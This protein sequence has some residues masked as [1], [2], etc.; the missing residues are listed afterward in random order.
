VS[1]ISFP[2][3]LLGE[4]GTASIQNDI[5]MSAPN[6]RQNPSHI[7]TSYQTSVRNLHNYTG[8]THSFLVT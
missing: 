3:L 5:G 7:F 4:G 2:A 1:T 8:Y 6:S